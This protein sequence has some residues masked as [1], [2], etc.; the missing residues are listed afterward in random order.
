MR[1]WTASRLAPREDLDLELFIPLISIPYIR[2]VKGTPAL[3]LLRRDT[4]PERLDIELP[5]T[6]T[7]TSKRFWRLIQELDSLAH[8]CPFIIPVDIPVLKR[9]FT[10]NKTYDGDGAR[11]RAAS[12]RGR[13]AL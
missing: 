13:Q 2:I 10:W 3:E 7:N 6:D 12:F 1:L 9:G 4:L 5:S 8:I 11:R